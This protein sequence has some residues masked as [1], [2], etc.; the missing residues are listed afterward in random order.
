MKKILFL[1]LFFVTVAQI[2]LTRAGIPPVAPAFTVYTLTFEKENYMIIVRLAADKAT[3]LGVNV[4]TRKPDLLMYECPY[5]T[6]QLTTS[7]VDAT[8]NRLT[9]YV[10]FRELN[11]N[12]KTVHV[13]DILDVR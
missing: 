4:Y 3:I 5:L 10:L 11:W 8:H 2:P 13:D 7:V 1:L 6:S 9:G 12:S